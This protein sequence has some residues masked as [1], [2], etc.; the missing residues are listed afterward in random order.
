ML[1]NLTGKCEDCGVIKPLLGHSKVCPLCANAR[2]LIKRRARA[3]VKA[4]IKKGV[5][6]MR[7]YAEMLGVD[8]AKMIKKA[9]RKEGSGRRPAGFDWA[10]VMAALIIIAA[11]TGAV[12]VIHFAGVI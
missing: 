4:D 11:G 12:L 10:P 9:I 1:E 5:E 2:G 8:P 7:P 6:A 3:D